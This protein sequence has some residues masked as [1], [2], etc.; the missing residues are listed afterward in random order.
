MGAVPNIPIQ[1]ERYFVIMRREISDIHDYEVRGLINKLLRFIGRKEIDKCLQKYRSSLQSSGDIF[2]KYYLER[3]HPWWSA[4]E[5]YFELERSG[6]SIKRHLTTDIKN[7]GADAKKISIL[8]KTMPESV[9]QKY[10]RNLTDENRAYDHLFEIQ[11]AWHFY[12]MG[13][14]IVWYEDDSNPHPE[15]LAKASDFQ[16]NVECKRISIDASKKIR[17]RDFYRF[18]EKII[19]KLAQHNYSGTINVL[20]DDRLHGND[21]FIDRLSTEILN[22]IEAGNTEGVF[23][24]PLGEVSLSLK[25]TAGLVI[26]LG[27]HV[28]ALDKK[29]SPK[30]HGAVFARSLDNKPVDPIEL[31]L[32]SVKS[33]EVLHG[34]RDRIAETA[35]NQL[36]RSMPGLIIC[37]LEGIYDFI[38][39]ATD[40]GLQV[41][42]S[43]L[44]TK[45]YL[46]HIAAIGYYAESLI[47]SYRNTENFYN[48]GLIYRNPLC[49]F[50]KAKD[51]PFMSNIET[52]F[53]YRLSDIGKNKNVS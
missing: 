14:D 9:R 30:S 23:R 28:K 46:S 4:L 20:I 15:Y 18:A 1:C 6:K 8:Y 2:R 26:D 21:Q 17:R 38:E 25:Q 50:E 36:D 22:E 33:N 41:M 24:I 13:Y 39:L 44:L 11:T 35:K 16:F 27:E 51:F 12:L 43:L 32:E 34:I 40:S 47:E 42:T 3:R 29:K 48:K 52:K 5:K 10:R 19:S 7:L 53:E 31:T 49:K 37:H 45:E